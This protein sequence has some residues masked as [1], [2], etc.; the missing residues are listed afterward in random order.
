MFCYV[1]INNVLVTLL[2]VCSI[3]SMLI[4]LC[5]VAK[6]WISCKYVDLPVFCGEN[7]NSV[8]VGRRSGWWPWTPGGQINWWTTHVRQVLSW[9]VWIWCKCLLVVWRLTVVGMRVANASYINILL[10]K[11]HTH[12]Q[13]QK[14]LTALRIKTGARSPQ[15]EVKWAKM[16]MVFLSSAEQTQISVLAKFSSRTKT[17]KHRHKTDQSYQYFHYFCMYNK[18]LFISLK[19]AFANTLHSVLF[20]FKCWNF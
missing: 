5:F 18:S 6:T 14:N 7:L 13:Q 19:S 17:N 16:M 20:S 8:S 4:C 2:C 1:L 10:L 12:T 11:T 3:C 15:D 9:G